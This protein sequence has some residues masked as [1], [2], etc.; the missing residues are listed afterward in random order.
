MTWDEFTQ[1]NERPITMYGDFAKTDITCPECGELIYR[2]VGVLVL[3]N[4]P[5]YKYFCCKCGWEGWW[6]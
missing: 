1:K 3:S 5:K 4:I 2:D 6:Y